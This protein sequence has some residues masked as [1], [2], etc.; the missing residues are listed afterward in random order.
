MECSPVSAAHVVDAVNE[1]AL[2]LGPDAKG[3]SKFNA[4][5]DLGALG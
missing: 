5:V 1:G 3:V 4:S 2:C